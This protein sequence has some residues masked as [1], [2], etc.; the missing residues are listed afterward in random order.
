MSHTSNPPASLAHDLWPT[1]GAAAAGLRL[2]VLPVLGSLLLWA[3]AKVQVPF[4]PV[5]MT[6]QT[7]AVILVGF[8]FGPWL[9]AATV[10]LYLAQGA[11]GLP[12]FAGTPEKGVGI[13]YIL[14]PTGGYLMGFVL[15]AAV[16]G[17][18]AVE[19]RS[20]WVLLLG[21]LAGAALIYVPGLIWLSAFTGTEIALM[22]G[23][24]PFVLGDVVKVLLAV[25][26]AR[27][28]F[29]AAERRGAG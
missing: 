21:G 15:A 28:G 3:S 20:V 2:I 25:A 11:I 23:L 24:Y 17:R 13:L 4:Y 19:S 29:A 7:G 12:V 22:A 16:A 27:V 9:G 18:A 1:S 6:L 5:P 8:A 14:G 26:L 10:L